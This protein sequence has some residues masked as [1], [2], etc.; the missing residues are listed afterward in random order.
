MATS[1]LYQSPVQHSGLTPNNLNEQPEHVLDFIREVPATW[2]ETQFVDGYPG[3]HVVLARRQGSHCYVVAV[4]GEQNAKEVSVNLPM[5][6]GKSVQL[7][8]DNAN[9]K[10]QSKKVTVPENGKMTLSLKGQGGVVLVGR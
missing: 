3:K 10:T 1:V 7:L 8:F 9:N 6:A 5:L 2:D 4:N